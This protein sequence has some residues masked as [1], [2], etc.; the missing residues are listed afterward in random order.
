MSTLFSHLLVFPLL[1]ASEVGDWSS[2]GAQPG[3]FA[4]SAAS[5]SSDEGHS[6]SGIGRLYGT[7][8]V[9]GLGWT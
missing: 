9:K 4:D 3:D 8:V 5:G 6:L 2:D 1:K 7:G